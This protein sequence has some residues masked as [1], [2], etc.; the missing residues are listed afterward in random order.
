MR[1][2]HVADPRHFSRRRILD[3]STLICWFLS[4]P[5][6]AVQTE[7]DRFFGVLRN[8]ADLVRSV[9]AQ[10]LSKARQNL[11]LVVFTD[12]T[13]H[14]LGLVQRHIDIPLWHGL[15]VVAA[16][17][18]DLRLTSRDATRRVIQCAKVFALYLPGRLEMM[19]R[20]SLYDTNTGE[21]QMLFEHLDLLGK[22]DLLVLDRGYPASWLVAALQMRSIGFCM[23]IDNAGG[24]A[25]RSFVRSG[26]CDAIVTLPAPNRADATDYEVQRAPVTVRLIRCTTPQGLVRVLA[27]N[28]LDANT[29]P[30]DDFSALYH[31]R[32]RI[33]EAFKRIKHRLDIEAVT[34]LSWHTHEQD[35][36]AKVLA[37]NLAALLCLDALGER[38]GHIDAAAP[39]VLRTSTGTLHKLNRTRACAAIR[40]S[41]PRWLCSDVL[42]SIDD[43]TRLLHQLATNVIRFVPGRNRPRPP[44]PKPHKPFA[45]KH[46]M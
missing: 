38:E 3:F 6:A 5:R 19:L 1:T 23:R 27:T 40:Q 17:G 10:A 13:Q 29:W 25:V 34:G 32:W 11:P 43:L 26:A 4:I 21:R 24:N 35:L 12:L 46:V 41:L 44:Q 30:A 31:Q 22:G 7:L 14:L 2:R 42:P 9:S 16:D 36:A 8:Q 28:L 45:A 15:R 37:D 18:S 39:H 20:A 33:E